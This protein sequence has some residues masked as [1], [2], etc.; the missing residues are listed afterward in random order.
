[1]SKL[2]NRAIEYACKIHNPHGQDYNVY[3]FMFDKNR[4]IS[5]GHNDMVKVNSKAYYFGKKFSIK[6][7]Q[8]FPFRHAELDAISKLWGKKII[9]GKETM[10]VVRLKK[11]FSVGLAKPCADCMSLL[12]A[13]NI[14]RIEWSK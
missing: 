12:S 3:A 11:N 6:Q 9:T 5:V 7:F 2:L 8:K 4:I 14:N 13:L 10:V 1:M